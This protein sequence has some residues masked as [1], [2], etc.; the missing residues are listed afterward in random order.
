MFLVTNKNLISDPQCVCFW[1]TI[2][3]PK[4]SGKVYISHVLFN[5]TVFP[6]TLSNNPFFQKD[7]TRFSDTP[8]S[9][10]ISVI[11]QPFTATPALSQSTKNTSALPLP[12]CNTA[13]MLPPHNT[14]HTPKHLLPPQ[15]TA[16]A[17]TSHCCK[18]TTQLFPFTS[19][20][21]R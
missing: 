21:T 3:K 20:F 9:I 19:N 11:K 15:N 17:D 13:H 7:K 2:L 10:P 16:H 6:F 8:T 14:A 4:G 12:T 1:I 5:E 18:H